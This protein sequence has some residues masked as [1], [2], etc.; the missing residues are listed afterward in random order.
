MRQHS[1]SKRAWEAPG[2]REESS[3]RRYPASVCS[4]SGIDGRC[5][6]SRLIMRC[7]I[8]DKPAG[9]S[10]ECCLAAVQTYPKVKSP[11]PGTGLPREELVKNDAKRKHVGAPV[12]FFSASMLFRRHMSGVPLLLS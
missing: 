8:S 11:N 7:T 4:T 2:R 6:D 10:G 5:V 1:Q 9:K 12:D 3:F